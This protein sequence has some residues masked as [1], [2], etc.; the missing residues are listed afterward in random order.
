MQPSPSPAKLSRKPP[1]LAARI[2][3]EA[4]MRTKRR[5][6]PILVEFEGQVVK[7]EL[8]ASDAEQ[9]AD[10]SMKIRDLEVGNPSVFALTRPIRPGSCPHWNIT[11][12][13]GEGPE[14]AKLAGIDAS[15]DRPRPFSRATFLLEKNHERAR[16]DRI[17]H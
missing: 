3:W 8:F 11:E 10:I 5:R 9:P 2:M 4:V 1:K 12:Q 16:F 13:P 14:A 17:H 6:C 7:S 15:C